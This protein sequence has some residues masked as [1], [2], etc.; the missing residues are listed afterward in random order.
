MNKD[1]RV[2]ATLRLKDTEQELLRQ[3]CIAINKVLIMNDHSPVSESDLAHL[4][5]EM[6][7]KHLKAD[8]EGNVFIDM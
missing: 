1:T 5:L 4:V 2:P 8:K 3:K 7:L 6:T